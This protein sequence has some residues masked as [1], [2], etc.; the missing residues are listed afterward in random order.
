MNTL[1]IIGLGTGNINNITL[2]AYNLIKSNPIILRTAI[3][4]CI[5]DF[6]EI[7]IK[8]ESYDKL[9][10]SNESFENIYQ[11]I[12][13]DLIER[14]KYNNIYYAVPGNPLFNEKTVE[15]LINSQANNFNLKIIPGLSYLDVIADSLKID[16]GESTKIVDAYQ[17]LDNS[18]SFDPECN[19]LI[20]E[21]WHNYYLSELKLKLMNFYP[22]ETEVFLIKHAGL[23]DEEIF[24]IKLFE[25]DRY[26]VDHLSS[27]LIKKNPK[28]NRDFNSLVAITAHLR[29]PEGC[30]WD[31][32]QTH[33]SLKRY[34]IEETYEVIEALDNQDIDNLKEELGDLL[35]EI[36]IHSQIATEN[37]EF[38]IYD[39]IEDISTKMIHR[40]PH[41]FSNTAVNS[42][43]EVLINWDQIKKKEKDIDSVSQDMK[44]IPLQTPEL[45]KSDKIQHKARKVGFDWDNPRKAMEKVNEE[46]NEVLEVF[47]NN[48]GKERLEE[49]LGDLIFAIVNV[50]R[51]SEIDP[52]EAL[53]LANKKFINRFEKME[54]YVK[55]Q[56][57]ELTDLNLD[58]LENIW[59]NVK[60]N[61]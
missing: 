40:H 6:E 8:F 16:L 45:L 30:P 53:R 33:E 61:K 21:V 41:V 49:E 34:L 59:T 48:E 43:N 18:F 20:N 11:T 55:H 10:E 56:G 25:L 27:L 54:N 44:R 2:E 35:F 28:L 50:I 39:V 52:E 51:L 37:A 19:L 38:N 5:K 9:Y 47:D 42:V 15:L 36:L 3:H 60:N 12:V 58:E 13:D 31:R 17:V 23:N 32:K 1:T 14:V 4:P 29:S 22:D 7:G 57:C 24:Q 26:E 46:V